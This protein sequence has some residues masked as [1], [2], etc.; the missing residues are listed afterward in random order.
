VPPAA[1]FAGEHP[2][3]MSKFPAFVISGSS[4]RLILGGRGSRA[5]PPTRR[6]P[7]AHVRC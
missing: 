3:L 6:D 5:R 4:M 1:L 2:V 7:A